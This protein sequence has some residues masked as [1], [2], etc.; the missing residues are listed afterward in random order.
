MDSVNTHGYC[1]LSGFGKKVTATSGS[2]RG[3]HNRMKPV[4]INWH[5]GLYIIDAFLVCPQSLLVLE[6]CRC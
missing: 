4:L 3:D 1:L 2:E 5:G 6:A